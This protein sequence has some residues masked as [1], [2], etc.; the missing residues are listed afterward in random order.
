MLAHFI[1]FW[2]SLPVLIGVISYQFGLQTLLPVS[3][4][5]YTRLKVLRGIFEETHC[6][7]SVRTLT[8]SLPHADC[9][10]VSDGKFS[11]VF[12]D[13]PIKQD[14]SF[15]TVKETRAGYAYPGLWDGHGHLIQYGELLN[16]VNIFGAESM[17]E[18]QDRL[19]QY[20]AHH[21]EAGTSK[22]W[23]R[24]VGWDQAR[25]NGNWPTSVS[26]F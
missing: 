20:K 4:H 21:P 18:V 23:L 15:D 7:A 1:L 2:V 6:Y 8:S 17:T 3:I 5:E 13:D 25:F 24:G 9:F 12:K 16:S 26:L 10:S 14:P 22:Q 11:R 19:L